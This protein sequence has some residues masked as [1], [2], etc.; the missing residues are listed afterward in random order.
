MLTENKT[1]NF[2]W[3]YEN[4][5][6][7]VLLYFVVSHFREH[8]TKDAVFNL[9]LPYVPNAR[10]DRVKSN[11]EV[12]TLKYFCN[13]INSMNFDEVKVL[14]A[15]SNVS[16]ALLNRVV[17]DDVFCFICGAIDDFKPDVL[18]F[19]DEGS[20]KRYASEINERYCPDNDAHNPLLIAYA[21]KDR[22]WVSGNIRGLE[23][24]GKEIVRDKRVLIVDDICSKGGTFYYSAKG[25]KACGAKKVALYVT[26][27]EKTVLKGDL[28]SSGLVEKIY[29]TNSLGDIQHP[30][31]ET[32]PLES[33]A[34]N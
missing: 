21:N 11:S 25:L 1:F 4:D 22:D 10:M 24:V 2:S 13:F 19:P 26:H 23:I 17:Q 32:M 7:M 15:H 27:C 16:L 29:T 8:S 18:F 14:D 34:L 6:E 5:E 9:Y 31:I 20:C 30:L 12:F 28:I 33:K 3:Y